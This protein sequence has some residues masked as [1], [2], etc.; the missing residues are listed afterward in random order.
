VLQ[1]TEWRLNVT[2]IIRSITITLAYCQA[3]F[4]PLKRLFFAFP[5]Y[6]TSYVS[7]PFCSL[8]SKSWWVLMVLWLS[9][10]LIS[11]ILDLIHSVRYKMSQNQDVIL[12]NI[13]IKNAVSTFDR[14]STTTVLSEFYRE[15]TLQNTCFW[16]CNNKKKL[17][18][19]ISS[20]NKCIQP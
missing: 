6:F 20:R 4:S 8:S 5:S 14:L 18:C 11:M 10:T 13:S 9:F 19:Q 17:T 16:C 2:S 7:C 15:K 1:N 3:N 12:W